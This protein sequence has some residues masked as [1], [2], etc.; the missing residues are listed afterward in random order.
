MKI[1]IDIH[2][3]IDARPRFFSKLTKLLRSFGVEIHITTGVPISSKVI[4][5]LAY[6]QISY[7]HLFSITDYH[8]AKGTP[9]EWDENGNPWIED[10]TWNRTKGDYCQRQGIDLAIDDSPI[11]EKYFNTPYMRFEKGDIEE[12]GDC[13]YGI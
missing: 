10:E 4:G 12:E 6:W 13:R 3:T 2:E 11:Y 7:D 9:I 5:E 8:V 1:A